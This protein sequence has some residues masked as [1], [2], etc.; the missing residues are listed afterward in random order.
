[1]T[2]S[3]GSSSLEARF[4]N[5]SSTVRLEG[6]EKLGAVANFFQGSDSGKWRSGVPLFQKLAYVGLWPGIDAVY[7]HFNGKLQIG[8]SRWQRARMPA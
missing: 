7:L 3:L 4:R 1:M 8:I 6:R 2:V 5:G